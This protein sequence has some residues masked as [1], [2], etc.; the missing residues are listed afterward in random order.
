MEIPTS[1]EIWRLGRFFILLLILC[2]PGAVL[3]GGWTLVLWVVFAGGLCGVFFLPALVVRGV[4]FPEEK[5]NKRRWGVERKSFFREPAHTPGPW[6]EDIQGRTISA[7]GA[8]ICEMWS[9]VG[10][11]EADANGRLV[12]AAP[13]LLAAL[14]GVLDAASRRDSAGEHR[15]EVAAL[16]AIAK[17]EK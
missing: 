7:P 5:K 14:K 1:G 15:A 2:I 16:A 6:V 11:E 17:A 9:A 13:D 10:L 3:A 8:V 12:A 4:A